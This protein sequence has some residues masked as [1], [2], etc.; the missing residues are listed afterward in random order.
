MGLLDK[1]DPLRYEAVVFLGRWYVRRS[2]Y[3][4]YYY[5]VD[6]YTQDG[7]PMWCF[8]MEQATQ[9]DYETAHDIVRKLKGE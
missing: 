1:K 5:M 9:Y 7:K 4:H 6:R 3:G 2:E 8:D